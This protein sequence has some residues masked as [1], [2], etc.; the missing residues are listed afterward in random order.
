MMT[1]TRAR[2]SFLAALVSASPETPT[3]ARIATIRAAA[4]ARAGGSRAWGFS[5]L[6][7]SAHL[8]TLLLEW[9]LPAA[10]LGRGTGRQALGHHW[11]IIRRGNERYSVI[12]RDSRISPLTR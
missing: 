2:A 3:A 8:P 6:L 9:T 1:M 5:C 10:R 7:L 11:V 4:A 12:V